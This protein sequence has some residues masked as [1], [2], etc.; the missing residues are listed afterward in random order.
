M[1]RTTSGTAPTARVR[2][3]VYSIDGSR[4]SGSGT[5]LRYAAVLSTLIGE[6]I[7]MYHIRAKRDKPGL[8]P[9][10]LQVLRACRTL[11]SGTLEGDD[12]GSTEIRYTPGQT[13]RGGQYDLDIGTAGSATMAALSL[14]P[15]ASFAVKPCL[16]H[17]TG[18]LFQD[19]APTAFHMR[20]TLCPLLRRMGIGVQLDM[21]RPGYVPK[22]Q[23]RI[24]LRI[25]PAAAP[26]TPLQLL[27]RGAIT[28]VGG[29]SLASHLDESRVSERMAEESTRLL[30]QHGYEAR[31]EIMH[32]DTAVQKGAAL[33]I[34][35]ATASGCLIGADCTGRPGRRSEEIARRAVRSLVEDIDSGATTDR[36]LADQLI[37]FGG[38]ARGRTSYRIP[39]VSEHVESNLWLVREMLG[40][41]TRIV[42]NLLTIDGIGFRPFPT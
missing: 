38:L 11:S 22:G 34:R 16:I 7:H 37:L 10:H 20:E 4:Y 35:A 26:L 21:V 12:V 9:Q 23:G 13:L 32:D 19:N 41:E 33:F 28:H 1:D 25:E 8:R 14:I 27:E 17:I 18:G 31:I 2:V 6:P 40:A 24:A 39:G 36:H 3:T 5:V 42:G 30:R 15:L 29:I